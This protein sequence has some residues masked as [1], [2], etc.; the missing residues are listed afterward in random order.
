MSQGRE[1]T[2]F[3]IKLAVSHQQSAFS[4]LFP[5][6]TAES[7]HQE[8]E[9]MYMHR[10]PKIMVVD[11][12]LPSRDL[13]TAHLTREGYEVVQ[14]ENGRRCL[15]LLKDFTPDLILLDV[16]MPEVNGFQ[17]CEALRSNQKTFHI[18]VVFLSALSEKGDRVNAIQVGADDFLCKPFDK[19]ELIAR[20]RSLLRIKFQHQQIIQATK[21]GAVAT[22]SDGVSHEF[23]NIL[24][25]ID[26]WAQIALKEKKEEIYIKALKFARTNCKKG[27]ELVKGLQNY[28]TTPYD[29]LDKTELTDI[30]KL[31]EEL[32]DMFRTQFEIKKITLKSNYGD[33]PKIQINKRAIQEVCLN[34]I[35]NAR[36]SLGE[37]QGMISIETSLQNERIIIKF[38]DTGTGIAPDNLNKIFEPFYTTK[39]ALGISKVPGTGLGLYISYGII[40]NYGGTIDVES[41][42]SKGSKFTVFLPVTVFT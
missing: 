10:T 4:F 17:V 15:E 2:V 14:A 41:E 28:A 13:V 24:A 34:I 38:T 21:M 25:G 32:L 11:D 16:M 1:I 31:I 9:F 3:G 18:P 36:D 40:K 39:G 26:G 12:D 7:L 29:N 27:A 33:I 22:L 23:N 30:N 20:V 8:G 5:V 35:T 42:V 6:L 37:R 19:S